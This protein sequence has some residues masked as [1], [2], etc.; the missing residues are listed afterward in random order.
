ML[1]SSPSNGVNN[2][3]FNEPLSAP[4][5]PV[6][7]KHPHLAEYST[8]MERCRSSEPAFNPPVFSLPDSAR[9]GR[10]RS[11]GRDVRAT[12]LKFKSVPSAEDIQN[13][14]TASQ[15]VSPSAL[16]ES[17]GPNVNES[18]EPGSA[19]ANWQTPS[20]VDIQLGP[21]LPDSSVVQHVPPD[22]QMDVD[23]PPLH[24]TI[25]E[26]SGPTFTSIPLEETHEPDAE[27][28][29]YRIWG[30]PKWGIADR[31]EVRPGVRTIGAEELLPLVEQHSV[32][33]TPS[34]V[35]FPWLHG[36]SDDGKR[37]KDM[38]A[39]FGWASHSWFGSLCADHTP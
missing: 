32:L 5:T 25:A 1:A 15:P 27:A 19:H 18:D 8:G 20:A 33:D 2:A 12:T 37:G 11:R 6:T 29:P 34:H 13:F 30:M 24:V 16:K 31:Q 39:F 21:V 7:T 17:F 22:D 38:A 10:D 9:E 14:E 36:I 26:T 28:E 4:S 35:L 3:T 23:E